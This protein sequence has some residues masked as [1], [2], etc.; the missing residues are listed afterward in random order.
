MTSAAPR[1][2][3]CCP[4]VNCIL[5]IGHTTGLELKDG[6]EESPG[7]GLRRVR[8]SMDS[9]DCETEE[10]LGQSMQVRALG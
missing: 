5:S 3:G 9:G 4:R 10:L 2:L 1:L 8:T 6:L 7:R